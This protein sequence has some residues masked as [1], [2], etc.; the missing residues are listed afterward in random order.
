MIG[1]VIL[2]ETPFNVAAPAVAAAACSFVFV[3]FLYAKIGKYKI[4][5]DIGKPRIDELS[6]EIKEGSVAFLKTAPS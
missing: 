5:K 4:G 1:P 2:A 6:L 3:S